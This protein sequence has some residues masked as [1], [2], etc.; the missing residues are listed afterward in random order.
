MAR[1]S[2]VLKIKLSHAAK[3]GI[4][5]QTSRRLFG[6]DSIIVSPQCIAP[7]KLMMVEP[8]AKRLI[9]SVCWCVPEVNMQRLDSPTNG[10]KPPNPRSRAVRDG[11]WM[12]FD[13]YGCLKESD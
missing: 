5:P 4:T 1:P 11:L 13:I 9:K 10:I 2:W 12:L 3:L 6:E 8:Y 7:K